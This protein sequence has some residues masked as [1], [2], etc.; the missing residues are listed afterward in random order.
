MITRGHS[1]RGLRQGIPRSPASLTRRTV[2]GNPAQFPPVGRSGHLVACQ[3]LRY[4]ALAHPRCGHRPI[5]I[6]PR[7]RG[8]V[9]R[10]T[11]DRPPPSGGAHAYENPRPWP[12]PRQASHRGTARSQRRGLSGPGVALDVS[13]A[14]G[15]PGR[16]LPRRWPRRCRC[17]PARAAVQHRMDAAERH[18]QPSG[19]RGQYRR[20]SSRAGNARRPCT[21]V[22]HLLALGGARP[23]PQARLRSAA[24][25]PAG[26]HRGD[27]ALPAVRPPLGARAHAEGTARA[28]EEATVR[29]F[30]CRSS[31]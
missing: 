17:T 2:S 20:G 24:R 16:T 15:S 3:T 19:R 12:H 6:A 25:L 30:T 22:H 14:A 7:P 31:C 18:R 10:N 1:A 9:V 8:S 29:S 27:R 23:V 11:P 4:P 21:A 5:G 13:S 26:G 28:R